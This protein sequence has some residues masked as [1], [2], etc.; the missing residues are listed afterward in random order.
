MLYSY[1]IFDTILYR[2]VP[3][4]V[5]VFRVMEKNETLL[6]LW[7]AN[8]SFS[9]CRKK[10]EFWLRRIQ[11][12]EVTISDI[13]KNIQKTTG[14]DWKV[15][16]Q[17]QAIELE[18]EKQLCF[19][20]IPIVDEIKERILSGHRVVLISDMYWGEKEI[21]SILQEKNSVFCNIPIYVSCDYN[22][23]KKAGNLFS[24]VAQKENCSYSSWIH[25][26]DN[27]HSDCIVPQKL[28]I[29]AIQIQDSL[30]FDF[31]KQFKNYDINFALTYG[32][33]SKSR[34]VFSDSAA[35]LGASVAGP[36]VYQ[37]VDWVL[38]KAC[39]QNI[40]KL[41][42]VLRDGYIP[43]LVADEIICKRELNIKTELLFGS[44]EAWRFP[45]LTIDKL[46]SMSVWEKSNWIFRDPCYLYVALERLGF[47]K[48][49]LEQ[50]FGSEYANQEIFSFSEF[51]A[52]LKK[53]LNNTSFVTQLEDNILIAK[54]NLKQYL[55]QT[56]DEPNCAF[57]DTN[58][59]GKTQADLQELLCSDAPSHFENLRFFYHTF[60]ADHQPNAKTQFV[61]MTNQ[62]DDRRFPEALFRA[63]YNPCYGYTNQDGI[64]QP[65][66]S[67]TKFC[68]WNGVF[69]YNKYVEGILKFTS[70]YESSQHNFVVDLSKYTDY[71][72]DVVNFYI[73]SKDVT[74][75]IAQIP[76][77]PAMDGSE[78]I[79]FYPKLKW[80]ALLH[81]FSKLLYYPR[82]SYYLSGNGWPLLYKMLYFCVKLK[83]KRK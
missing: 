17:I 60:L 7:T 34:C 25:V 79:D 35:L 48:S 24:V 78:S 12:T 32:I 61:F 74:N 22:V 39:E 45:A 80:Q 59:T 19:L 14:M 63:P 51:D 71:L 27:K 49:S 9:Q 1:D 20:N 81:P 72:M 44:R 67:Q 82:V 37:Y 36:M 3:K 68:A 65:K 56:I 76:F 10:S 8:V 75:Q 30:R 33:I 11:K 23:S 2:L 26:G 15:L 53:A 52:A 47:S 6:A 70:I 40:K 42:F 13:Y 50:M 83:R 66:F 77:N 29:Q 46:T 38:K 43:K 41:Y 64:M 16:K 69:D 21:R 18:T 4:S 73:P 62:E 55:L 5:D 54:N 57:V 28:G 58:S 31:E